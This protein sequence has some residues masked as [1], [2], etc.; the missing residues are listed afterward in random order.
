MALEATGSAFALYYRIAPH[1]RRVVVANP[2]EMRR[3][4]SGRHTDRL[5]AERLVAMHLVGALKEVWV[6]PAPIAELRRLLRYRER[7]QSSITRLT[8]QIW[9]TLRGL[10]VA[11]S[12]GDP[13]QLLAQEDVEAL[14]EA[15]RVLVL[16]ALRRL[17]SERK[18]LEIVDAEIARRTQDVPEVKLLLSISGVGRA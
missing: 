17:E 7:I 4:G 10:G 14:P 3:L 13:F 16:S 12:G 9:A 11:T 1:V 15:D 18:E 2:L 5:D 6:P 8:N